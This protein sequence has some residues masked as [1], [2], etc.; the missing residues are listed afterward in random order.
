MLRTS[1]SLAKTG[2]VT[3]AAFDSPESPKNRLEV[4]RLHPTAIITEEEERRLC[5][6]TLLII[7]TEKMAKGHE[8]ACT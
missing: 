3:F 8:P 7:G 4:M 6:C 1:S 2:P 5:W